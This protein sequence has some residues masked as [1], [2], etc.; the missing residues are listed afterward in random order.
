MMMSFFKINK[1][2]GLGFTLIELMMVVMIVGI[3][4]AIAFPSY[5]NYMLRGK[6][7]EGRAILM[8]AS[9]KMEKHYG[10]CFRF[11]TAIAVARNCAA[12]QVDL[13]GTNL[14]V[15]GIAGCPSATGKYDLTIRGVS[16]TTQY[17]LD[18]TPI[19]PFVDTVC[20]VLSVRSTGE[21]CVTPTDPP[22]VEI[23]TNDN[24]AA[25]I[26]VNNCWGR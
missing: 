5:N 19:L 3:L 15:G 7:A 12:N 20:N 21:K 6:R 2:R 10:D 16:T 25:A 22:A 18:V 13:C 11:G 17:V 8:D 9:S 23:C 1:S 4:A 24:V 14:N 26:A